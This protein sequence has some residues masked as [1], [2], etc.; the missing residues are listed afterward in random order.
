M[1]PSLKTLTLCS[2]LLSLGLI[3]ASAQT[4]TSPV[5]AEFVFG[6]P[7]ISKPESA[8]CYAF[9]AGIMPGYGPVDVYLAAWTCPQYG[10]KSEFTWQIAN[11]GTTTIA[12]SGSFL[13]GDVAD[14]EVG[15]M[16]NT[17]TSTV[18]IYVAYYKLGQGH[19]LDVYDYVPTNPFNPVQF[20]GTHQLSNSPVYGRIRMDTHSIGIRS[21]AIVWE[22]PGAGINTLVGNDGNFANILNLSGTNGESGPDVAFC[23]SN[24]GIN[25]HYVYYNNATNEITE[26]YV[27]FGTLLGSAGSVTPNIEDVNALTYSLQSRIVLDAPDDYTADNWAYT[28]VDGGM[29]DPYVRYIDYNSGTPPTT[30][31]MTDGSLFNYPTTGY[32]KIQSPALHYGMAALAPGNPGATDQIH[33]GWYSTDGASSNQY[34][35]LEMY[36][37]GS[38]VASAG[39]YLLLPNAATPSIYPQFPATG[40]AFSKA[41]LKYA[42]DFLYTVYYDY[43]ATTSQYEFHHAFHPWGSTAFSKELTLKQTAVNTYPNPFHDRISTS[44]TLQEAATVQLQLFD[45]AGRMVAQKRESVQAGTHQVQMGQLQQTVAGTYFL[46]TSINGKKQGTQTLIK[47]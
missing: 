1:L 24:G 6:D 13:Y 28:Y 14:L 27:D 11:A 37:D 44:V 40:I 2:G 26:S 25:V 43:N 3:N 16:Y 41:D 8:S 31:S 9:R 12:F 35:G 45:I 23:R 46:T 19:F 21:L 5:A 20:I 34:L 47:Q 32:Y 7:A 10:A 39:D 15:T 42:P 36:A 4:Y 29:I 17:S 38:G 22:E 18:Q 33:V 30:K